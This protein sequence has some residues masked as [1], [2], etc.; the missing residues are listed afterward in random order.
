MTTSTEQQA[1]TAM[2]FEKRNFMGVELDVMTGHPEHDLL[3]LG[4]QVARCV[5]LKDPKSSIYHARQKLKDGRPLETLVE[6]CSTIAL[7]MDENAKRI[8]KTTVMFTEPELYGMLLRANSPATLPFR[9]WVTEE[10]LPTIR[11][12][13]RYDAEESTN[14]IAQSLMDELKTLRG[15]VAELKALLVGMNLTAP[16]NSIA[17]PSPYIGTEATT[18]PFHYQKALGRELM[19]LA[20]LNTPAADKATPRVVVALEEIVKKLWDEED[21]PI[22]RM[23]T[24]AAR[25]AGA[26]I[27][28]PGISVPLV[29]TVKAPLGGLLEDSSISVPPK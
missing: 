26:L 25:A 19:D 18:V 2:Q 23:L 21:G 7:P 8:R 6:D 10:V 29:L 15:D 11:K 24:K 28:N 13:G 4:T 9:K 17:P 3:F 12:T 5:G 1:M 14:P 27:P 20:G 16:L 22:Y